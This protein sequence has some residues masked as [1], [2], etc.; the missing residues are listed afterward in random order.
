MCSGCTDLDDAETFAE[1]NNVNY[2]IMGN[3][4]KNPDF[5]MKGSYCVN[6]QLE[7]VVKCDLKTKKCTVEGKQCQT[8]HDP[9]T[10]TMYIPGLNCDVKTTT[11]ATTTSKSS[12]L[13]SSMQQSAY[14]LSTIS[15][16]YAYMRA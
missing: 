7:E 5:E 14:L 1:K 9:A 10:G 15:V 16:A 3:F 12:S 13:H 6:K 2:V 11:A 4:G 8:T